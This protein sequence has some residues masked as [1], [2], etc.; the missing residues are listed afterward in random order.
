MARKARDLFPIYLAP[1][2][3]LPPALQVEGP[4]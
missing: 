1:Q 4:T 2:K 3:E